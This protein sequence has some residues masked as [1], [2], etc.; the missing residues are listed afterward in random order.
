MLGHCNT[1][2]YEIIKNTINTNIN[3]LEL[4]GLNNYVDFN[5]NQLVSVA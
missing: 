1:A 2:T 4:V 5:I 3:R